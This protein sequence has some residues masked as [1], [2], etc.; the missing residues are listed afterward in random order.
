MAPS[1][2]KHGLVGGFLPVD[3][4]GGTAAP[5]AS[6]VGVAELTAFADA[7]RLDATTACSAPVRLPPGSRLLGCSGSVT[8]T[9]PGTQSREGALRIATRTRPLGLEYNTP[10]YREDVPLADVTPTPASSGTP[11]LSRTTV[12]PIPEGTTGSPLPTGSG[13]PAGSSVDRVIAGMMFPGLE[14]RV[15]YE[16]SAMAEA[17]S[18]LNGLAPAGDPDDP[19]TWPRQPL[20]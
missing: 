10:I 6:V 20:G 13:G 18:L 14:V 15:S 12:S 5:D 4:S 19:S 7:V 8:T 11:Q 9:G 1:P 3:G 2:T 17:T 16:A